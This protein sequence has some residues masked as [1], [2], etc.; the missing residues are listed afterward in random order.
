VPHLTLPITPDGPLLDFLC[1]VSKPRADALQK[2]RIPIPPPVSVKGLIDTGAS[3]TSIDPAVL[4]SIGVVSTGTVPVHTPSTKSSCPHIA[5]QFDVSIV[6]AHP[7]M[8]RTWRAVPVIESELAH[9]GIQA[10]IGRDILEYCLM[11][12]DGQAG[13]FAIGF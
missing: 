8:T 10:L 13:T 7:L 12:Y 1:G 11:T 2:A 6:L 4:K 5:N 3:I 9:A